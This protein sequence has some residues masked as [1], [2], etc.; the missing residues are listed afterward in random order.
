MF[1]PLH[2]CFGCGWEK[3]RFVLSLTFWTDWNWTWLDKS[4][5]S[6]HIV[7]CTSLQIF[8]L[9]LFSFIPS[10]HPSR[11]G[12]WWKPDVSTSGRR[13]CVMQFRSTARPTKRGAA[14]ARPCSLGAPARPLTA[15]WPPWTWR[16]PAPSG[17]SPSSPGSSK[18]LGLRCTVGQGYS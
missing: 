8:F 5:I 9:Y 1:L 7:H 18:G 4:S 11:A 13:S 12:C 2:F 15:S 10:I 6:I 16:R 14:W 3:N 17:P